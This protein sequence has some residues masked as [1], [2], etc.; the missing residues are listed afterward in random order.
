MAAKD[1]YHHGNL[2]RELLDGALALVAEKGVDGLSLRAV[3]ARI[4]VSH[5]APYHH[6]A[7]RTALLR[8]LAHEGWGLM[9]DAMADA[10]D[11]S[12]GDAAE[13]LLAI[14]RAYVL[15]STEHPDYYSI[16]SAP[17][18]Q[19]P[20]ARF[21]QPDERDGAV[22]R[23][24]V[25]AVVACQQQ[26]SMPSGD[27]VI[28]AIHLWS[29]VHGLSDLWRTGPVSQMPQAAGGLEPLVD[30]VLR[31]AFVVPDSSAAEGKDR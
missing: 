23:R 13:R 28:V 26:G 8:E 2:R 30:R 1:T 10:A 9:G 3:A 21:G 31:S 29:L 14:G 25:E 18:L 22:W 12:E 5:T 27:P 11:S 17:E 19:T 16:F 6:F 15:F 7:D 4:G 20:G 24:L